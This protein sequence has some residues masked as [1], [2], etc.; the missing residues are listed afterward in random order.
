MFG[1]NK[2]KKLAGDER[3]SNAQTRM[4]V[5]YP[6][7]ASMALSL[8]VERDDKGCPT[9]GTDGKR[10]IYNEDFVKKI[11]TG[12]LNFVLAHEVMHCAFGHIW[13]RGTR[14]AMLWN[15][16]CDYAVNGQLKAIVDAYAQVRA[17]RKDQ[18]K[19]SKFEFPADCL[20]DEK[21]AEWSAEKIYKYI[22]DN[23]DYDVQPNEDSEGEGEGS[24]GEGNGN[25]DGKDGSG[26]KKGKGKGNG[27]GKKTIKEPGNHGAWSKEQNKGADYCEQRANEWDGKFIN[28]AEQAAQQGI[29]PA[30]M[31]LALNTLKKPQRN[32]KA[33]LQEYIQQFVNDYSFMPPDRR[34]TDCD[35]MLPDFN[36]TVD[37]VEGILFAVDCSGSMP[38]TA[39]TAC[40]SEIQG[41][42]DQFSNRLS[43]TLGFFDADLYEP[44]YEFDEVADISKIIPVG[45]GGTSYE[46]IFKYI[47]RHPDRFE[48]LNA[49]V[50]MTDGYCNYPPQSVTKDVPVIWVYTTPNNTA[51]FG[52]ALTIDV[53]D[54]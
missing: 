51:P 17:N 18:F 13:R 5:H 41:A 10:L 44:L 23:K 11:S 34:M 52:R 3:I 15:V 19:V 31:M 45:G 42:I 46:P 53:N 9:M 12:E 4:I 30:G 39:I 40:F 50:I 14:Q 2:V 1:I 20:Y 49:V 47:D 26:K 21:F 54:L 16:A 28:A 33:A 32:W 48:H 43:G 24:E 38:V 25:G 6:F 8:I 35:F 37:Y 29:T 22:A 36:D 27:D 7:F